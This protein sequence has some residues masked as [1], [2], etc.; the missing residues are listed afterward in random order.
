MR[1]RGPRVRTEDPIQGFGLWFAALLVTMEEVDLN[2]DLG[3]GL[4]SRKREHHQAKV[5]V[6]REL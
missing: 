4:S 1:T 3:R 2:H 6:G 5:I